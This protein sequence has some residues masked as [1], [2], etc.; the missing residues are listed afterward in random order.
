MGTDG[1]LS[2]TIDIDL[3]QFVTVPIMTASTKLQGHNAHS[4][5][6][7]EKTSSRLCQ[8]SSLLC[9]F[10][11]RNVQR[12]VFPQPYGLLGGADLRF[13]ALSQR[14]VFTLRDDGYGRSQC[15]ARCACL[16]LS[17]RW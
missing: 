9:K 2:E 10:F 13:L 1:T 16:C 4:Q 14:P 8:K 5:L 7:S 3:S 17:F 11:K 12:K 6:L 15:I